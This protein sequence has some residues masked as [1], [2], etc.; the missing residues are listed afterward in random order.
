MLLQKKIISFCSALWRKVFNFMLLNVR[1]CY[2]I[3]EKLSKFAK[4]R[5][6]TTKET[7]FNLVHPDTGTLLKTTTCV[8]L[9]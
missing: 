2:F 5:F 8:K 7:P 4:T 6:T 1:K 3:C 9:I